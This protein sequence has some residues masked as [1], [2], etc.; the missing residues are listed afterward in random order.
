[1][2]NAAE[3]FRIKGELYG[4]VDDTARETGKRRDGA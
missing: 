3:A 2:A 1:M 4:V